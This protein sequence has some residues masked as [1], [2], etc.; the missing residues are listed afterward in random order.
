MPTATAT[1]TATPIP[2]SL[3][4]AKEFFNQGLFLSAYQVADAAIAKH[5]QDRGLI[6]IKERIIEFEPDVA[7][8]ATALKRSDFGTVVRF[9]EPMA[10]RHPDNEELKQ[11]YLTSLFNASL[12]SMRSYNMAGA[13][14]ALTTLIAITP[15]DKEVQ[16]IIEFIG[17]YKSRPVDMQLEIFIGSISER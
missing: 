10:R 3:I 1:P 6:D 4:E 12:D 15:D 7:P 14:S 11:V 13:Q 2:D 17:K 16:R 5:P 8:L 9:C